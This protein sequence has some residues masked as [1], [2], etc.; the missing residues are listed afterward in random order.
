MRKNVI[1]KKR[2]LSVVFAAAVSAYGTMSVIDVHTNAPMRFYR[3]K[4]VK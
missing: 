2:L 3:I 4:L 1:E